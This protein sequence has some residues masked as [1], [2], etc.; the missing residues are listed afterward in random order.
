MTLSIFS[1]PLIVLKLN[2]FF[3]GSL[4][5]MKRI[6]RCHPI[7][8]F[9]GGSGYDPVPKKNYNNCSHEERSHYKI[10]SI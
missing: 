7:K 6:L 3:K 10:E 5:G 1:K 4:L 8:A 9:G 2:G